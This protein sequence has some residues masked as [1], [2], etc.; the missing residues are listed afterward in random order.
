LRLR[1]YELDRYAAENNMRLGRSHHPATLRE[2]R[3]LGPSGADCIADFFCGESEAAA[4]REWC[5][6][7]LGCIVGLQRHSCIPESLR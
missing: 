6:S 4:R 5:Q 1:R 2:I 3:Q 7:G